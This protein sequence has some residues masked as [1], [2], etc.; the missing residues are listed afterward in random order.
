MNISS[1]SSFVYTLCFL[2]TERYSLNYKT[3]KNFIINIKFMIG[4][5]SDVADV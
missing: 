1:C 5:G 2:A 4:S 3:M